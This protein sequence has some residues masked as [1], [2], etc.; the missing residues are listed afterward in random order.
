MIAIEIRLNGELKAICGVD[1]FRQLTAMLFVTPTST[2]PKCEVECMGLCSKDSD[3][4]N[5]LRWV[6]KTI[7]FG[8][9]VTFKVVETDSAQEPFDQQEIPKH[10]LL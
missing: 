1:E 7:S 8:D 6:K 3:T 10:G 4:D 2:E 5:V 9:E